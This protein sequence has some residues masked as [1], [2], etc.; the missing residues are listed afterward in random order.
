MG[1]PATLK[2]IYY[3]FTMKGIVQFGNTLIRFLSQDEMIWIQ[4]LLLSIII[5]TFC[6]VYLDGVG[7]IYVRLKS[8]PP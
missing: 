7:S 1:R 6:L 4:C 2:P 8:P 5:I 3:Q